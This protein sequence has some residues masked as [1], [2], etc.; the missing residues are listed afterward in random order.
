[1]LGH[2]IRYNCRASG[3]CRWAD[4]QT[5][6]GSIALAPYAQYQLGSETTSKTILARPLCRGIGGGL[7]HRHRGAVGR[8]QGLALDRKCRALS[9]WASGAGALGQCAPQAR[10][11]SVRDERFKFFI[12]DGSDAALVHER[13]HVAVPPQPFAQLQVLTERMV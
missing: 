7:R 4:H 10:S 5:L 9:S 3:S 11:H 13:V 2:A 12:A 8:A 6:V 1:M